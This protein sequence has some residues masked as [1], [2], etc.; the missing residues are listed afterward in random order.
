MIDRAVSDLVFRD[1]ESDGHT[2]PRPP[3]G[4]DW[5]T[6]LR[7]ELAKVRLPR[8]TPRVTPAAEA[9][10]SATER[11]AEDEP[12]FTTERDAE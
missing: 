3:A 2:T 7:E 4:E 9:A 8:R 11:D 1:L 6:H 5:E 12:R 10:R